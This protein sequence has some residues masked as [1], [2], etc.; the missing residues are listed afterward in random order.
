M[1]RAKNIT[2]E[3]FGKLVVLAHIAP[4]ETI[5]RT[6]VRCL[7]DCGKETVVNHWCVMSGH[8]VSCGCAKGQLFKV[9][10]GKRRTAIHNIWSHMKSRCQTETNVDYGHYGARG[11]KVCERWQSFEG[12]YADMGD[13]PE[14]HSIERIDVDGNYEPGN[15][16]WIPK[17][18]QPRNTRR[19]RYAILNGERMIFS[20][21]ARA[22]GVSTAMPSN[23]YTGKR[24][25][26]D[27]LDLVFE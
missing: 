21:V 22:L 2:G 19:T 25:I 3:R 5:K 20:D 27:H 1:T 14:G 16:K 12:F 23:W 6:R 7:C 24:R 15:C 11:I 13:C 9:S 18:E 17:T 10:H 4:T 26:P 8:T